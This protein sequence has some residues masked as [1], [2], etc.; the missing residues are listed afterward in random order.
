MRDESP[1]R[2][3]QNRPWRWRD[4]GRVTVPT[5]RSPI[6]VVVLTYMEEANI[7]K[8]LRSVSGWASDI[9]VL[10][11]G[12][13]D[14]TLSIA[15]TYAHHVHRHPYVD[16]TTQIHYVLQELPLTNEWL[17][18]LDADHVV[19]EALKAS[20]D[21]MLAAGYQAVDLFY[22]R[23]V[24]V[25]RGQPIRSL[26]K[27]G[28]LLRH[29]KVKVEGGELVDFRYRV[30]GSTGF[31]RGQI[32]E[33][34]R[35]E[36]DLDFWIDKH[37]SFSTRMAVEETLRR[38]GVLTWTVQPRFFG[39]PDERIIWLR[40]RWYSLPLF[41][42]PF[43]YFGYRYFWR[44]GFLDGKTGFIYDFLQAFWFRLV[45]DIKIFDLEK[46]IALGELEM[47]ELLKS[48]G[49]PSEVRSAHPD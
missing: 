43:L 20:V 11:S 6:S 14:Q 15:S 2:A 37:Q 49:H 41:I 18:I 1:S 9:H 47:E 27:W 34:N 24:Y 16:H 12:S 4:R 31:L 46:Q 48:F 3:H 21:E 44:L 10:D 19:T 39:N 35:K 33:S 26:N 45:V 42:R 23:Q 40:K 5:G 32:I 36:D 7:E 30:K 8:C 22:C 17:I 13:T 25:F 28:R 29:R 38:A